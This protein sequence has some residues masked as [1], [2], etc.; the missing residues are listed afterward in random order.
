MFK[1]L[2]LPLFVSSF[3]F[4]EVVLEVDQVKRVP[5]R[6]VAPVND[7]DNT[8]AKD[9]LY[10]AY[11]AL[12]SKKNNRLD[13][14]PALLRLA[15]TLASLPEMVAAENL[16]SDY[17]KTWA[18]KRSDFAG[19]NCF[20]TSMAAI[21]KNWSNHR[22]MSPDEFKCHLEN[23]FEEVDEPS[24]WGDLVA[25]FGSNEYPIH[26][27]T[28]LGKSRKSGEKIV[29][30]KNGYGVSEYLFMSYDAVHSIYDSFGID[31]IAYYRPK[32]VALDPST[33]GTS[34]C[35]KMWT[36]SAKRPQAGEIRDAI[37]ESIELRIRRQ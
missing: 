31:R 5:Y 27:F 14:E 32:N 11:H 13:D 3:C 12:V 15:V 10:S 28:Y 1:S 35:A 26:G 2:F 19:P 25:F 17:A 30:T 34:A 33:D 8:E 29:F 21:F 24:K 23:S 22:Y 20:H 4:A 16:L 6:D 18:K 37:R 7:A 9:G 36:S